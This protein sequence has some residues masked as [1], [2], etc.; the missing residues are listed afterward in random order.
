MSLFINVKMSVVWDYTALEDITVKH[1]EW[2]AP[3]KSHIKEYF[4][5]RDFNVFYYWM[6]WLFFFLLLVIDFFI[7]H[8]VWII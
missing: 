6:G 7:M 3:E 2:F 5:L 8:M 1:W 4:Y